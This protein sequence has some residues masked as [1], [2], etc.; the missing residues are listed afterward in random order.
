MKEAQSQNRS[1]EFRLVYKKGIAPHPVAA[2]VGPGG[3][4][5]ATWD[6]E[7]KEVMLKV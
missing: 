1:N 3:P 7:K 6:R 2:D 4:F 5:A